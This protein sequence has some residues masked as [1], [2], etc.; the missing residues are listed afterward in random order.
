MAQKIIGT[1]KF[2]EVYVATPITVCESRDVK[3]MYQKARAGEITNFTGVSAPYESP[4]NPIARIDTSKVSVE[5]ALLQLCAML[6]LGW[7]EPK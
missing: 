6:N 2:F 5:D 4:D 3:W 7:V 1:D